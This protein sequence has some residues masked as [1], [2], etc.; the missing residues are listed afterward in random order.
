MHESSKAQNMFR[1]K[2]FL[3]LRV[4]RKFSRGVKGDKDVEME[5]NKGEEKV[6]ENIKF[7]FLSNVDIL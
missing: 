2:E 7:K 5:S 3:S 4:I 6:R 1:N